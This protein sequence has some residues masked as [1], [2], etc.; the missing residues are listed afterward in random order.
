MRTIQ[1][2]RVIIERAGP[3]LTMP[4][5]TMVIANLMPV[6]LMGVESRWMILAAV[7]KNGKTMADSLWV[8][9]NERTGIVEDYVFRKQD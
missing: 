6:K 8:L 7:D 3:F 4:L 5:E 2:I 1:Y 9:V